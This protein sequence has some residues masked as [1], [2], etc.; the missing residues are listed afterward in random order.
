MT[1]ILSNNDRLLS[2]FISY[3]SLSYW[4][5]HL[6][7][8]NLSFPSLLP[9]QVSSQSIT[10]HAYSQQ[11]LSIPSVSLHSAYSYVQPLIDRY[12]RGGRDLDTAE[13]LIRLNL[14]TRSDRQHQEE[15]GMPCQSTSTPWAVWPVSSILLYQLLSTLSLVLLALMVLAYT[16]LLKYKFR[17]VYSLM[18]EFKVDTGS[19]REET[20]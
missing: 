4:H 9:K 14:G 5:T 15:R 8:T 10:V 2:Q 11:Y 13:V 1:S 6:I 18:F 3:P 20:P 7:T 12:C 17:Y 16:A 19:H